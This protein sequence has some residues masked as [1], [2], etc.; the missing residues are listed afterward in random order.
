V[1]AIKIW[2]RLA[3]STQ[4]KYRAKGVTPQRYN[5]WVK[6]GKAT[7][8]KLSRRGI[9]RDEFLTAPTTRD[10]TRANTE[11]RAADRLL[12]VLPRASEKAVRRNVTA[13]TPT[14]LSIALTGSQTKLRVLAGK[15]ADREVDWT[16]EPVN[17]FWYHS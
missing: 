5:A 6:T 15:R 3:S 14:E 16:S 9:S 10:V 8:E 17:P 11:K 4:K 13:M 12:K 7:K 2:S 1:I